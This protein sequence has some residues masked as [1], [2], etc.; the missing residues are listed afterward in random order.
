VLICTA[1]AKLISFNAVTRHIDWSRQLEQLPPNA[2]AVLLG[3]RILITSGTYLIA[4]NAATGKPIWQVDTHLQ[5]AYAPAVSPTGIMLVTADGMAVMYDLEHRLIT[6][7]PI[8]LGSTPIFKPTPAGNKFVVET[9]NGGVV[10]VDP[11]SGK[12]LWDY[13]IPPVDE[14]VRTAKSTGGNTGFG[15]AGPG[16][17]EGAGGGFGGGQVGNT[18]TDDKVY[19]IQASSPAVLAGQTLLVPA[20]DGS[21]L[22]FDKDLGVDLTPPTAQMMFP[23]PGEQVNPLPPLLLLFKVEDSNSGL[24]KVTLKVDVDGKPLEHSITK[25]GL[26]LVRFSLS[27]KNPPLSNGR[28]VFTITAQDWLGNESKTA[29]ALVM[30]TTLP[31][32]KLPGAEKQGPGSGFGGGNNGGGNGDSGGGGG[33]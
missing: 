24:N 5:I 28:H 16:G 21:I 33:G 3:D 8:V 6:K 2:S 27:G 23:R 11:A 29:F 25:E 17:G 31:P 10:L 30:D 13:I 14:T 9:S 18:K 1:N 15:G 7:K 19:F 20:K 32:I 4:L 26:I 22:A 12:I